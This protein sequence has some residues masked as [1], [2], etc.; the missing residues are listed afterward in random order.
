MT[1]RSTTGFTL[2]EVLVSVAIF[3]IA[4]TVLGLSLSSSRAALVETTGSSSAVQSLRKLYLSVQRDVQATAFGSSETAASLTANGGGL[5]GDAI[6]FLSAWDSARETTIKSS[7]GTP[8]WQRNILYYTA[9]PS[10][11]SALYGFTCSGGTNGL[12]YDVHCPHKVLIRKVI[13][14]GAVTTPTDEATQETLI[15]PADIAQYL[16]PPTGFVVP[17]NPGNGELEARVICPKLLNFRA[18]RVTAP[19]E[20]IRFEARSTAL[21]D[22]G[23]STSVGNTNL[24]FAPQTESIEF[25]I[26]PQN[27]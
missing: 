15:P 14:S 11:H 4:L 25:S 3:S 27:S 24:Q 7:L 26:F 16:T 1:R 17:L 21:T 23:K 12:G 9:V 22:L 19:V 20:E 8:L 2:L 13:D 6:W 10:N 5:T 18:T